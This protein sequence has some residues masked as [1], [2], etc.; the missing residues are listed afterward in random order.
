MAILQNTEALLTALAD[1]DV[2]FVV[3]GGVAAHV[4]GSQ[5]FTD[6]LDVLAPLDAANCSRL[7][8]ALAPLAPAFHR[9]NPP[10]LLP[11]DP[12]ELAQFRNLY[13]VTSCGRLDVLGAMPPIGDYVAVY[14]G[15]QS[16]VLFG[17][18]TRVVALADLIAV[19]AATGRP[20]DGLVAAE[21]RAIAARLAAGAG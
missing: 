13:L 8:S 9:T 3:I 12:S 15:A 4:H 2:Q 20:K 19:K 10:R 16:V 11:T 21:L 18:P 6:D 14:S 17:R 5:I 7:I 1:A